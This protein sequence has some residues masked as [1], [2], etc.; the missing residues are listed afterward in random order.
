MSSAHSR[1]FPYVI[2]LLATWLVYRRLRRSF[3]RQELVRRRMV[4]RVV[5][6]ALIAASILPA[7]VTSPRFFAATVLGAMTG[8]ALGLW[9]SQRTRFKR[10]DGVLYYVP[11]THT[12][13]VVSLLLI[14]RLAYRLVQIS[15]TGMLDDPASMTRSPITTG[16]FSLVIGYYVVY[17]SAVLWKSKHI[18]PEDLEAGASMPASLKREQAPSG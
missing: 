17:Y 9:G 1:I 16:L 2:A 3:G 7:A 6:F 14:A 8:V 15:A 12:G 5:V 4:L 18:S 10:H 13:I 11:H